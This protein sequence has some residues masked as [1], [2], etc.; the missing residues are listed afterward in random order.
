MN[1]LILF[2]RESEQER[3][4]PSYI[5]LAIE[6]KPEVFGRERSCSTQRRWEELPVGGLARTAATHYSLTL[7]WKWGIEL[8]T[9]MPLR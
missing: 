3:R 9:I 5:E 6:A 1:Y 7:E 2:K 4:D 8:V